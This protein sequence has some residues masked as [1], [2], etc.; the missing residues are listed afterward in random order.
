MKH[1][2]IGC[3]AIAN[4]IEQSR[5]VRPGVHDAEKLCMRIQLSDKIVV[6]RLAEPADTDPLQPLIE[7]P[8]IGNN[9]ADAFQ[10]DVKCIRP[11]EGRLR[12]R[13]QHDRATVVGNQFA[14]HRQRRLQQFDGNRLHLVQDDHAARDIV[15]LA[16]AA[17]ACCVE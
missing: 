2:V 9:L 1:A 7:F 17:R 6:S 4:P 5:S 3:S 16:T 13:T 14:D 10:T 15:Q 8:R 12:G 11:D